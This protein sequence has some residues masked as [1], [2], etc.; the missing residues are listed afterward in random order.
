MSDDVRNPYSPPLATTPKFL[1]EASRPAPRR[2]ISAW[3]LMALLAIMTL[4]IAALALSVGWALVSGAHT[5]STIGV[6]GWLALIAGLATLLVATILAI[7]RARPWS[8][9][10]GLALIVAFAAIDLL[11][12]DTARYPNDGQRAGAQIAR[13]LVLPALFA[14]WAWAFAFTAKARAYFARPAADSD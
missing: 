1:A 2:P 7:H 5:A 6:I 14:W 10:V 9:W 8:R 12:T 13:M 4:A 11:T 3:I